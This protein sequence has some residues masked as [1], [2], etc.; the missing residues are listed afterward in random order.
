[1]RSC[2][3]IQSP[4][5]SIAQNIFTCYINIIYI[6]KYKISF[7][8]QSKK[9]EKWWYWNVSY[10]S[11]E[12]DDQKWQMLEM[13]HLLNWNDRLKRVCT[14]SHIDASH[15]WQPLVKGERLVCTIR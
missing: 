6:H 10:W 15:S 1:M 4:L 11:N 3:D 13:L 7:S 12:A 2:G 9:S 14:G 5:L 8:W